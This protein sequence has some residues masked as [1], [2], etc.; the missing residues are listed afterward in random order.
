MVTGVCCRFRQCDSYAKENSAKW[1]PCVSLVLPKIN[2]VEGAGRGDGHVA[3]N[4]L[5]RLQDPLR[6]S[7]VP[8][9]AIC[10]NTHRTGALGKGLIKPSESLRDLTPVSGSASVTANHYAEV[11]FSPDKD[12]SWHQRQIGYKVFAHKLGAQA[13]NSPRAGYQGLSSGSA[14]WECI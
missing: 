11:K 6:L 3:G 1:H 14:L 12:L 4:L 7:C 10:Q 8:E 9:E 5:Q 13:Q 2:S